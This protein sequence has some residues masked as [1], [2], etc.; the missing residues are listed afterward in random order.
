M[1][2]NEARCRKSRLVAPAKARARSAAA[3]CPGPTLR[4]PRRTGFLLRTCSLA[5]RR[6]SDDVVLCPGGA[7]RRARPR[8]PRAGEGASPLARAR[9]RTFTARSPV[10]SATA[11]I[12]RTPRTPSAR[13]RLAARSHSFS[14][15]R[16]TPARARAA[17]ASAR[18]TGSSSTRRVRLSG[19]RARAPA[20]PGRAMV[21]ARAGPPDRARCLAGARPGAAAAGAGCCRRCA[22][23]ALAEVRVFPGRQR[24]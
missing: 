4:H 15:E 24:P 21:R 12:C 6:P 14:K 3:A 1:R 19:R 9:P 7:D 13:T 11:T 23:L 17:L 18:A 16:S 22:R 2:E 10:S 20:A 8:L 5:G